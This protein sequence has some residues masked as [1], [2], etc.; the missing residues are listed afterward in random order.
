MVPD[1]LKS[2]GRDI[3]TS[4]SQ[5]MVPDK[6]ETGEGGGEETQFSVHGDPILIDFVQKYH[7]FYLNFNDLIFTPICFCL[8]FVPNLKFKGVPLKIGGQGPKYRILSVQ[9]WLLI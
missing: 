1:Q 2:R 4:I 6:L 5:A 8:F 7:A 3:Q 9:T